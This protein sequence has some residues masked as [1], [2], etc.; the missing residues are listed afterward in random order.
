MY[1]VVQIIELINVLVLAITIALLFYKFNGRLHLYLI[2]FCFVQLLNNFGYQAEL[3]SSNFDTYLVALKLSYAGRIWIGFAL[4]LFVSELCRVK[5]PKW[6]SLVTMIFC[7]AVFAVIM[8]VEKNNLY[9][10]YMEFEINDGFPI[11]KHGNGILYY[12]F[13]ASVIVFIILACFWLARSYIHEKNGIRKKQLSVVSLAMLVM[14]AFYVVEIGH[15]LPITRKFDITAIGYT[16][17][18]IIFLIA[19]LKYKLLDSADV[20]RQFALD[21]LAS[22]SFIAFDGN[23]NVSYYNKPS[24][25]LFPMI[26]TDKDTVINILEE[27]IALE[28]PIEIDKR[29][30]VARRETLGEESDNLGKM[31]LINDETDYFQYVEDLR[32]QKEIADDANKAKSSFLANMSHEIRSPINAILGMDEMIIRE[33]SEEAVVGYA[34]DIK[35]SSKTLLSIVND[36]LDFSKVEEGKMEIIPI[37]YEVGDMVSNLISMV[38]E[39]IVD[40]GLKFL[41]K[42]DK[43]I[44]RVLF[45]DEIRIKQCVLNLLTNALKYTREGEI[46][47]VVG[48]DELEEDSISLK[49]KVRDTGIGMKK[50]DMDKLFSPFTRIEERRNR[51]VE[52]TG[53]GMSITSKL[54]ELMGTELQVESVYGEGSTFSFGVKQN[55][56]SKEPIGDFYQKSTMARS[57]LKSYKESFHA[58]NAHLL[59]IDDTEINLSVIRNLLKKTEIN[60]DTAD[61]AKNGIELLRKNKYDIMLIDHMMP[62]MDGIEALH[63]MKDEGLTGDMKCVVL[64]ANAVA[65]VREMY[66]AEGFDDYLSKPVEPEILEQRLT[67]WLPDDK[68]VIGGESGE[69]TNKDNN[70]RN[71]NSGVNAVSETD[72]ISEDNSAEAEDLA[73]LSTIPE[74]DTDTGVA[75]CGS[76]DSYL[77]IIRIFHETAKDKADEI[78]TNYE[79]RDWENFTVK[80]HALKS[81]ARV[82]G[83]KELSEAARRMEEAGENA[84]ID[85]IDNN[86]DSLLTKFQELDNK[87]EVLDKDKESLPILTESMRKDAYDT[88]IDITNSMDYG[89]MESL[90][91]DIDNYKL[92]KED[93]ERFKRIR[94][95]LLELDWEGI[96][97]ELKTVQ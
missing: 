11:I 82:I 37:E 14:I 95:L 45:G 32:V 39:R 65:G 71:T 87:L 5:L 33:S 96:E 73:N 54:L 48:Y 6:F 72:T 67:E 23:G 91:D 69:E 22:C 4:L 51:K 56:I 42:V 50:E 90:L 89:M 85:T 35:T 84:D 2:F 13:A 15:L 77:S 88:M 46:E 31:Y 53:L 26:D 21:E 41:V 38:S 58:P 86:I 94:K 44:P 59:V 63:Y 3:M 55:V 36:I 60:I 34:S 78:R 10:T 97:A 18:S 62:E 19:I 57:E 25:K 47:F 66:M 76:V 64:T 70:A 92:E 28:E 20:A 61:S 27:H 52:G 8:D 49:F 12:V 17:G 29:M 30:Y 9:Y 83:A 93:S 79:S 7:Y 16:L 68:V 43:R 81:S 80:V 24:K 74:L 40:K 1:N 75:Y